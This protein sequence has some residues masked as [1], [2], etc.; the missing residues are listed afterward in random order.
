VRVAQ[1]AQR[2]WGLQTLRIEDSYHHYDIQVLIASL[3][4]L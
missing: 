2:P 3:Q 1:L 4:A